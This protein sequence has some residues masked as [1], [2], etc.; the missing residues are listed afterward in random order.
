[1]GCRWDGS[2]RG[3]EGVGLGLD[4]EEEESGM[5]WILPEG[6]AVMPFWNRKPAAL[7]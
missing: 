3:V 1:M 5:S 7:P 6:G 2:E 4:D